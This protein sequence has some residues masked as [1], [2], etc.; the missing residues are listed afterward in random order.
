MRRLAVV[1]H[2]LNGGGAERNAA[3]MANWWSSHGTQV[4]L[5]TLD[6]AAQD[7]YRLHPQVDRVALDLMSESQS[8]WQGL[9]ENLRRSRQLRQAIE[10]ASVD[11]VI[12]LTDKMNVLTLFACRGLEVPIVISE[13]TNPGTHEIGRL[14]NWLRRRLYPRAHAV[15]TLTETARVFCS[16][17]VPQ[18]KL[19][20]IGNCVWSPAEL[21]PEST[22]LDRPQQILAVGRLAEEKGYDMLLHAFDMIADQHPDWQLAIAGDGPLRAEL[23]TWIQRSGHPERIQLLG[24]VDNIAEQYR[25]AQI[26]TLSSRYEGFPSVVLEAMSYALPVV[27]FDC[28]TGPAEIIRHDVDGL[29]I[30]PNDVAAFAAALQSLLADRAQRLRLSTAAVSVNERFGVENHFSAWDKVLE[31]AVG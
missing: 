8:R 18:E 7:R 31:Q 19:H 17:F 22:I 2:S 6:G 30:P 27:S 4:T 12:S 9:R 5:I 1:I 14:W 26:L 21:A 24:W 16:A 29:L 25:N 11:A 15:V 28:E 23:E 10:D 20:V 13:Q 3:E